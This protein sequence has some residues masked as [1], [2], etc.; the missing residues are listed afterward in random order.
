MSANVEIAVQ[1]PGTQA[2]AKQVPGA[3]QAASVAQIRVASLEH[4]PP[5]FAMDVGGAQLIPFRGPPR[6]CPPQSA[7]VV[8]GVPAEE[9]LQD[10]PAPQAMSARQAAPGA[11]PPEH[12]TAHT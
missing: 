9:S 8:H 12:T 11:G 1:A 6:H 3:T 5:H 7:L 4:T 10:P 2:L